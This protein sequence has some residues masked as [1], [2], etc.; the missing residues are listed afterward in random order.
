MSNGTSNRLSGFRSDPEGKLTVTVA[1]PD[2]FRPKVGVSRYVPSSFW[3]W[4]AP[5]PDCPVVVTVR[6]YVW[7]CRVL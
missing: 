1:R 4:Y 6:V 5:V 3:T 2:D 7:S